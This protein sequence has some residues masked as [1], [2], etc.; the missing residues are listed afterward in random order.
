MTDTTSIQPINAT[1]PSTDERI[2][3]LTTMVEKLASGLN[4]F[5]SAV[6]STLSGQQQTM[7][8]A[9]TSVKRRGRPPKAASAT[10][11][12]PARTKAA[13]PDE[14]HAVSIVKRAG[15]IT[16]TEMANELKI[17][18]SLVRARMFGPLERGEVVARLIKKPG[19]HPNVLYYR[20]EWCSFKGE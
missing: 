8:A 1:V 6:V 5:S 13:T 7:P 16:Q 18:R 9:V 3:T 17:E 20:P 14:I 19:D 10:V 12:A 2:T 15:R 4:A 11:E